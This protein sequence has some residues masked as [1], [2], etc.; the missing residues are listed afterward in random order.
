MTKNTL[1]QVYKVGSKFKMN[2][3]K[4]THKEV[5]EEKLH[6]YISRSKKK[7]KS[8]SQNLIFIHDKNSHKTR[9]TGKLTQF[10]K[11]Y[12][13]IISYLTVRKSKLLY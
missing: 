11:E 4:P 7:K 6:D 5:K 10:D 12:F 8:I 3:S 2:E 1:S 13:P 9:N